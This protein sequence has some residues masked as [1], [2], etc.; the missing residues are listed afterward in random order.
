MTLELTN[1]NFQN[2]VLQADVPVLVDFWGHGCPPCRAVA[3]VVDELARNARGKYRVGKVNVHDQQD[4]GA[5][6]K[7]TAI[8][9]LLVFK[10]GE[11]VRKFVGAQDGRTLVRALTE[12]A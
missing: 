11:V 9:T 2:E 4:L 8:P 3:P 1:D 5:Q 7:I 6:F 10:G 12:V